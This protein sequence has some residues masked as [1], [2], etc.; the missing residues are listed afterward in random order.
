[1]LAKNYFDYP[2][3]LSWQSHYCDHGNC[4]MLCYAKGFKDNSLPKQGSY[5]FSVTLLDT[6]TGN[7]HSIEIYAAYGDLGESWVYGEDFNTVDT[8]S[9]QLYFYDSHYCPCHRKND[10]K[11]CGANTDEECEGNRFLIEKI[12]PKD[13]SNLILYSE[14]MTLEELEEN[15][16]ET[17]NRKTVE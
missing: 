13:Q 2:E 15:L 12:G 5:D 9:L 3:H 8:Y 14:I 17:Q 11:R 6:D 7:R 10:A 1:M 4:R 16:E